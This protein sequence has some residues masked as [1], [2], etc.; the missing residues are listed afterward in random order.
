MHIDV[1]VKK[2]PPTAG[3]PCATDK[4]DSLRTAITDL[5][6]NDETRERLNRTAAI[7]LRVR[8]AAFAARELVADLVADLWEGDA[9]GDAKVQV[10]APLLPQLI[11]EIRRRV[12]RQR[13]TSGDTVSLDQLYE[14]DL[15]R[16]GDQ[17][18]A[19]TDAARTR[20]ESTAMLA[21]ALPLIR[22]RAQSDREV[23]YLLAHFEAG[24]TTKADLVRA[25]MSARAYHNARRRLLVLARAALNAEPGARV[26]GVLPVG[27]VHKRTHRAASKR[28]SPS[29]SR[30][31]CGRGA[32]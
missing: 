1:D 11:A 30:A 10:D 32:A 28:S 31:D 23:A 14:H 9:E 18:V 8:P 22:E 3:A 7:A 5:L 13:R 20:D 29:R 19:E 2:Q 21:S 4:L 16:A 6:R 25:G 26:V 12:R 27:T 24:N 17:L 15:E